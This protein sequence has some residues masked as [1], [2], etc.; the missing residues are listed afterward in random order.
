M[1]DSTQDTNDHIN[2]VQARIGELMTELMRRGAWHDMS[3]L[4]EPEKSGYD[5]L[6]ELIQG[7]KYG[8]PEYAAVMNDP[9][10]K[11]AID[12][13]VTT[14]RHH[15]Q[16]HASIADMTLLD[17]SELLC[18]I[19]A[20]SERASGMPLR[21]ILAGYCEYWGFSEQL[22]SILENTVRELGW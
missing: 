8:T 18:D 3:K 15:P 5:V 7:V 12:H 17:I 16:A 11:P 20:A 10:V 21:E 14:N 13:H 22:T 4:R 19:K 1:Y 9:R 6:G 2:N